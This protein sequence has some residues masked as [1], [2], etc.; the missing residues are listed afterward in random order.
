M[1]NELI[2]DS[3]VDEAFHWLMSNY[4]KCAE[5][6]A[7]RLYLEEYRKTIKARLM[8]EHKHE[9]GIVQ[10]REAYASAGYEEFLEGL[11]QAVFNDEK[12]RFM[13]EAKLALIEAWRTA[14]SNR[15][16]RV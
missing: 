14:S 4:D 5:A 2:P 6:R 1:P 11:R 10:E 8:Q 9:S 16:A 7:H 15:R 13:R 12:L 3:A